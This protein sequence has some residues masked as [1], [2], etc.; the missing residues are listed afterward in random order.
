MS[1]RSYNDQVAYEE[2]GYGLM[3][4]GQIDRL[5]VA[6]RVLDLATDKFNQAVTHH[7][8]ISE[9]AFG[10]YEAEYLAAKERYAEMLEAL[11]GVP[12]EHM[13]RRLS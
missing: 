3:V 11:M 5:D 4:F 13:L 6:G 2:T 8:K 1:M 12:A 10:R 9:E 7:D